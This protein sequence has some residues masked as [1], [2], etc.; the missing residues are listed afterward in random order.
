MVRTRL[1]YLVQETVCSLGLEGVI[2]LVLSVEGKKGPGGSWVSA[3]ASGGPR[4][5]SPDNC[6]RSLVSFWLFRFQGRIATRR[7]QITKESLE[8]KTYLA[9]EC[10]KLSRGTL[11]LA[12]LD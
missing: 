6:D 5:G 4:E 12:R 10:Q 8:N 3:C 2:L 7:T 11:L 9:T 1:H